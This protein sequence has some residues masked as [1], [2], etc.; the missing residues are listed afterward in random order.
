MG[1]SG[2]G[3]WRTPRYSTVE[4]SCV[5]RVEDFRRGGALNGHAWCGGT[6]SWSREGCATT[7]GWTIDMNSSPTLTLRYFARRGGGTTATID[8]RFSLVATHPH[9]GGVRWWVRCAC[10]R[11]SANLYLPPHGTL[12]RCRCCCRLAYACQR[13]THAARLRRRA[14]K[15]RRR[16]GEE[17]V[18]RVDLT[19]DSRP[20][21]WMRLSTYVRLRAEA[22]R[23]NTAALLMSCPPSIVRRLALRS[24]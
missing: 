3:S 2:S 24:Y 22:D 5:L 1:G 16:L 4:Q 21:K 6:T 8:D 15:V 9:F 13:E 20:P 10:G 11:R 12:F 23:L 17:N 19:R 7:I 14:R 18:S